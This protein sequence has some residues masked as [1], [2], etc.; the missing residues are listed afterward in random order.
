[1]GFLNQERI[2]IADL[3]IKSNK[4]PNDFKTRIPFAL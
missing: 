2:E 4:M 1:M 3:P